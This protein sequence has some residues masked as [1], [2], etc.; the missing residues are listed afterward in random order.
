MSTQREA[1]PTVIAQAAGTGVDT[2]LILGGSVR[3]GYE[4]PDSDLDFFAVAAAGFEQAL[5]GF[6]LLSEK[7]GCRLLE[8]RQY[9]FPVHIACWSVESL[10]GVLHTIPYMT[11][12]LLDGEPVYDP[13]GLASRYLDRIR[14]YF[15]ARPALR[16]AWAGQLED[17]RSFKTGQLARLAFPAWSDFIRHI[18][19]TRLHETAEPS[20]RGDAQ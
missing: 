3:H 12:P 18:E 11:Y 15:D 2:G 9:D 10:N 6:S 5:R 7:N 1:I 8:T 13:V 4:R 14:A 20:D 19:E 17:I 16:Q